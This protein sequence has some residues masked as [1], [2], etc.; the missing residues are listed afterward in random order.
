M[1]S[2][3]LR[4]PLAALVIAI[5]GSVATAAA[6]QQTKCAPREDVLRHLAANYSEQPA[7]V[8]VTQQGA[9]MEVLTSADGT[10][11]ALISMPNGMSCL[12]A[13]GEGWRALPQEGLDGHLTG[14]PERGRPDT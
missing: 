4:Y 7:A 10:W 6:A 13:A 8:A 3:S 14:L 5:T 9:L 12:L 2:D 1:K 11:T